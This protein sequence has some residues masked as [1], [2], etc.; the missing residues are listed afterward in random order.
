MGWGAPYER[1][2]LS[3]PMAWTLRE[4]TTFARA[5][6]D[7][8]WRSAA[9]AGGAALPRRDDLRAARRIATELNHDL[10]ISGGGVPDA[11]RFIGLMP[12]SSSRRGS[13]TGRSLEPGSQQVGPETVSRLG[14]ELVAL[15]YPPLPQPGR[16]EFSR[17]RA[18]SNGCRRPLP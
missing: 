6:S 1:W 12:S 4:T 7:S 13:V 15:R 16:S 2:A 9:P 10:A 18:P 5:C 3:P 8:R 11:G 14:I 17:S